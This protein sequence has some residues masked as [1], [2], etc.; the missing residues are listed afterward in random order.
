MHSSERT[1]A[2]IVELYSGTTSASWWGCIIKRSL[3]LFQPIIY[4][5]RLL[6]IEGWLCVL[7]SF[8]TQDTAE[9]KILPSV[10]VHQG[11]DRQSGDWKVVGI[12]INKINKSEQKRG[13]IS[14]KADF[15]I[16]IRWMDGLHQRG[17]IQAK[18]LRQ[19]GITWTPGA[20]LLSADET[21]N[22]KA[23]RQN[24]KTWLFSKAFR[25]LEEKKWQWGQTEQ[26]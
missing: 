2:R 21:A 10:Y 7:P 13:E 12:F 18:L 15:A 24:K 11:E 3:L 9:K 17:N 5:T 8:Q 26:K 25:W 20:D 22:S 4:F 16:L 19:W 23:L 6:L 14:A 1:R